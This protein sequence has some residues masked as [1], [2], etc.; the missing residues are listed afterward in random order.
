VR[1]VIHQLRFSL[2]Q[3][4]RVQEIAL[5]LEQD[6]ALKMLFVSP[7]FPPAHAEGQT[8]GII[9]NRS[10][11]HA[12]AGF[13]QVTVLSFDPRHSDQE[14]DPEPFSVVHR[15]A[16]HWRAIELFMHWQDLVRHETS[17]VI[18]KLGN[19]DCLLATT[20]VLAAFDV[21]QRETSRCAI[22]R[23]FENFGLQCRWV[24]ARSRVRLGKSQIIRMFR[25]ARHL[26]QAD[27]V[28]TNSSFMQRAISERFK[29]SAKKIHVLTQTA[30]VTPQ[31]VEAPK[32]T[33]G[34]VNRGPEKNLKF[35]A[36]LARKA[37]DLRFLVFGSAVDLPENAPS[38][39]ERKGWQ[40]N[41]NLLFSSAAIWLVPSL[42]AE[43][44]GRV[45]IEAQ[46]ANR[47]VLVAET[48]GLPETV[49]RSDFRIA[50][51]DPDEWIARIRTLL[52][53]TQ[54]E[55]EKNGRQIRDRF[56]ADEHDWRIRQ[57]FSELISRSD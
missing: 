20:S 53:L 51:L 22:V 12:L 35:V 24:P 38:N 39:L 46:A 44:F 8:G 3:V 7:N 27:A 28:L 49:F 15:P 48:G 5:A 21:S 47:A 10:L 29:I 55:I 37:P 4:F 33:V 56:S 52:R 31:S 25:D 6:S 50:G 14:F 45:S 42:W 34:F 1:K 23:A 26:K 18:E 9:S 17:A 11:I 30:D 13:A 32:Y 19:V 40:S 43:P 16:P 36:N 41:R 57:L 2:P 54:E